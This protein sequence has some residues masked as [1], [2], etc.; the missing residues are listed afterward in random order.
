[1]QLDGKNILV[2]GGGG[3]LASDLEERLR[4][5][6]DVIAPGRAE[7]DITDQAALDAVQ[8]WEYTPSLLNGAPVPVT[9]TVTIDFKPS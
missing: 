4:D 3:Q 7:L 2:T 1:M 5:R 6:A 9:V 8:Q